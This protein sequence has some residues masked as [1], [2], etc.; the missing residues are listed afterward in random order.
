MQAFFNRAIL[1]DYNILFIVE[2]NDSFSDIQKNIMFTYIDT[3]LLY[4]KEKYKKS[5]NTKDIEYLNSC[6]IFIYER[7]SKENISFLNEINRF[8]T[9]VI[10]Y[11]SLNKKDGNSFENYIKKEK[12][13]DDLSNK[14]LIFSFKKE[15]FENIKVI[16]SNICG[17]GKS[18]KIKKMIKND[19]K[20]YFHFPL[21]GIL[22]KV[23]IFE[24]LSRLLKKIKKENENNYQ[25]VAIH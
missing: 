14:S 15:I 20:N 18:Y 1:C 4:K 12:N 19:K 21:G 9:K 22:T 8:E 10:E 6:I 16:T 23:V 13:I 17:L 2:I 24:K 7:N 11:K 5:E 3:L 25:E